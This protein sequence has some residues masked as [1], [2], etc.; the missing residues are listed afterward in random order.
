MTIINFEDG[1]VEMEHKCRK[2]GTCCKNLEFIMAKTDI[3]VELYKA[4]GVI[5]MECDD[6]IVL[7]VPHRCPKLNDDNTCSIHDSK[8][9][10]CKNWPQWYDGYPEPCIYGRDEQ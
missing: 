6:Y 4:R 9:E 2:C 7:S 3:N 5:S 8:P 10:A 1:G